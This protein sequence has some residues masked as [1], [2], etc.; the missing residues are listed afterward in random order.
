MYKNAYK[1]LDICEKH[2]KPK[3]QHFHHF[4]K[5][6]FF[7]N[8]NLKADIEEEMSGKVWSYLDS[9]IRGISKHCIIESATIFEYNWQRKFKH[10]IVVTTTE[11]ER[12]YRLLKRGM[13]L[14][15]IEERLS[16]QKDEKFYHG[17]FHTIKNTHK[18]D[19][20]LIE[21]LS[22]IKKIIL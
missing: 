13:S 16:A 12:E 6:N 14:P 21:E 17:L 11:E 7:K 20:E 5:D 4:L 2:G 22:N 1:I 19:Y 15:Q 8:S 18:N 10:I 3:D 9:L